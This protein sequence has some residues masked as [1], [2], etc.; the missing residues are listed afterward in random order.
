M[1]PGQTENVEF[2]F[3]AGSGLNYTGMAVCSVDGGP[4]YD[5]PIAGDSSFINHRLSAYDLDFGEIAYNESTTKDF[6]IENVGK[7]PFEFNIN[8]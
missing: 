3:Y 6:Y 4:D 8:L 1:Q 7:V 5:V 2:T